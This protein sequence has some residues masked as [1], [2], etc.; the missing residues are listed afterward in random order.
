[1]DILKNQQQNQ[2][3]FLSANQPIHLVVSSLVMSTAG[4]V[5]ND[6]KMYVVGSADYPRLRNAKPLPTIYDWIEMKRDVDN[7]GKDKDGKMLWRIHDSLYDLSD[8]KHPGGKHFIMGTQ[9]TDVTELFESSHPNIEL[10]RAYLAKYKVGTCER[11][12]NSSFFTFEENGFYSVLRKK[13]FHF[14]QQHP[15]VPYL[16]ST[17]AIHDILLLGFFLCFLGAIIREKAD[18]ITYLLIVFAGSLLAMGSICAHNFFHLR[19][20]WRMYTFD[21]TLNAS[22]E[23]RLSH[24]YSHHVFANTILDYEI[25]VFEPFVNYLSYEKKQQFSQQILSVLFILLIFPVVMHTTVSE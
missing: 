20:N 21:L 25:S 8:F 6:S 10:A 5:S 9:G 11:K 2:I 7:I 14:L 13:V 3:F 24:G 1:V 18:F 15:Q 19:D 23:W 12:R 4:E 16:Q 17:K 22:R